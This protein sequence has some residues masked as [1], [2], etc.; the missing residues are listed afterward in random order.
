MESGAIEGSMERFR[1]RETFRCL[2][3]T[4]RQTPMLVGRGRRCRQKNNSI[5]LLS[6]HRE[7]NSCFPGVTNT[8]Q[9]TETSISARVTLFQSPQMRPEIVRSAFHNLS[10]MDGNGPP[11]L[12]R[13][14]QVLN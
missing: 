3:V 1:C 7:R 13:R 2:S 4:N 9:E 14:F 6:G 10:G 11:L 5:V 12:L 8:G